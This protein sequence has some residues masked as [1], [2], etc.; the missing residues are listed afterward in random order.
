MNSTDA[1]LLRRYER[2]V[3][4]SPQIA[5]LKRVDGRFLAASPSF[6]KEHGVRGVELPSCRDLD[7]LP[8]LHV[9]RFRADDR[10]VLFSRRSDVFIEPPDPS[11]RAPEDRVSSKCWFA[12]VKVPL[13]DAQNRPAATLALAASLD[14]LQA[15]ERLIDRAGVDEL[16]AERPGWLVRVRQR[17]D[18][19][20]RK[21]VRVTAIAHEEGRHPDYLGQC[22]R[23]RY[24]TSIHGYVMARRV[25][26]AAAELART[27]KP[28]A[29][30]AVEA[31]FCDQSHLTRA[32]RRVLDTSPGVYRERALHVGPFCDRDLGETDPWLTTAPRASSRG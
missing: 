18:A 4:E 32:F 5:W 1:R 2:F 19:G 3:A 22:F 26:W 23:R 12:T 6:A 21:S 9:R 15:L 8:A 24:G 30:I 25:A 28:I 16:A 10:R 27:G 7:L 13:Y 20:F 29:E 17:L 31:G 11:R 14:H